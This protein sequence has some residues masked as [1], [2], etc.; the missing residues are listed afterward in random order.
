MHTDRIELGCCCCC[1]CCC[2]CSC[3]CCYAAMIAG[4]IL[5]LGRVMIAA[6]RLYQ[7]LGVW[8]S[9]LPTFLVTACRWH[10]Y[11]RWL[12]QELHGSPM[13]WTPEELAHL[14]RTSVAAKMAHGPG[15][16]VASRCGVEPPCRVSAATKSAEEWL[17]TVARPARL[18][19]CQVCCWCLFAWVASIQCTL[20]K[21]DGF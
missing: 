20:G 5:A 7:S 14:D 11:L 18:R 16:A 13:F 4:I 19:G 21:P 12:P 8:V 3:C 10:G 2:C 1:C 6:G 9:I 17:W 15:T